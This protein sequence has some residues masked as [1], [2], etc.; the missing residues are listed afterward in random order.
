[1][2]IKQVKALAGRSVSFLSLLSVF[3]IGASSSLNAQT[4]CSGCVCNYAVQSTPQL[5]GGINWCCGSGSVNSMEVDEGEWVYFWV[6]ASDTDKYTV[7]CGPACSECSDPPPETYYVSDDAAANWT[8]SDGTP[9]VASFTTGFWWQAPYLDTGEC[10]RQVTITATASDGDASCPGGGCHGG[11]CNDG[12]GEQD[13][14]SVTV[15]RSTCEEATITVS[16]GAF[17]P[18]PICT[19][20]EQTASL[21][22]SHDVGCDCSEEEPTWSWAVSSVTKDGNPVAGPW[23]Y[24]DIDHPD[25][26]S[27]NATLTAL[28]PSCGRWKVGVKATL[29]WM[30]E[31][32]EGSCS[33]E[34]E[35]EETPEATVVAIEKL[36]LDGTDDE[37]PKACNCGPFT[38]RAI[39]C[40]EGATFPAGEPV[41]DLLDAPAAWEAVH[42][43]TPQSGIGNGATIEFDPDGVAGAYV[44][45]AVAGDSQ[46]TITV[47]VVDFEIEIVWGGGLFGGAPDKVV[48]NTTTD[49]IV[50]LG[51]NLFVRSVGGLGTIENEQWS[52]SGDR[53]KNYVVSR[54]QDQVD[55]LTSGD[56]KDTHS[57]LYYWV[58]KQESTETVAVLVQID[59]PG[60]PYDDLWCDVSATFDVKRPTMSVTATGGQ[61]FVV[62]AVQG[63]SISISGVQYLDTQQTMPGYTATIGSTT[64][65]QGFSGSLESWAQLML[66]GDSGTKDATTNVCEAIRFNGAKL[67]GSFPYPLVQNKTMEDSPAYAASPSDYSKLWSHKSFRSYA[68]FTP[69]FSGTPSE[70]SIWIALKQVNWGYS[71]TV[72]SQG[73]PPSWAPG[74]LSTSGP[75]YG[76]AEFTTPEWDGEAGAVTEQVV[77]CP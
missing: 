55:A 51:M 30:P 68:V 22:A 54:D 2:L 70:T 67:D 10:S 42:G 12:A 26:T 47:T 73:S 34:S 71:A 63:A 8:A 44:F 17:S 15:K 13:S 3:A 11:N 16:A 29:N 5:D 37:A 19:F 46:A 77:P 6:A 39:P 33:E 45:K 74:T 18:D 40:P 9:G 50:G 60:Q 23:T 20:E 41:W 36:V 14:F 58:G 24:L 28:F 25:P 49:T 69:S 43:A 76:D 59:A 66:S 65:P 52:V 57:I 4:C 32:C 64:Y 61:V 1:M 21:S 35:E 38:I 31:S 56:L 48:S 72:T 62:P 7:D 27:S 75:T 53:I